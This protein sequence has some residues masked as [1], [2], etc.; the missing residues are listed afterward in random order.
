MFV[1]NPLTIRQESDPKS[2]QRYTEEKNNRQA[3][4][5][6]VERLN[7]ITVF[8][9]VLSLLAVVAVWYSLLIT[10]RQFAADQRP[11]ALVAG[12]L[13]PKQDEQGK[14]LIPV[15]VANYG[16]TPALE[17]TIRGEVFVG[18]GA[19]EHAYQY[20]QSLD[21]TTTREALIGSAATVAPGGT[22]D[23]TKSP[24]YTTL[25]SGPIS[26]G[27]FASDQANS[28]WLVAAARI[29]YLD[30][31]GNEYHS[32]WCLVNLRTGAQSLCTEHN[33]AK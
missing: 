21:N 7:T 17:T 12:T 25:F 1:H 24:L 8:G 22:A 13:P 28:R 19:N 4:L 18:P 31:S 15:Y 9:V 2:D 30:P 26:V 10:R 29:D 32:E 14:V 20:L 5:R 23:P 6:A 11:W 3:Q 16:K 27:D 33:I